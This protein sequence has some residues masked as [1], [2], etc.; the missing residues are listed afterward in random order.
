MCLIGSFFLF[1]WIVG[2]LFSPE[3]TK[4]LGTVQKNVRT[5]QKSVLTEQKIG[6]TV[7]FFYLTVQK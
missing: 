6:A 4:G 1:P 7:H 5:E 2:E 3:R